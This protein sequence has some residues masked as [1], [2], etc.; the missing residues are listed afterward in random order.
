MKVRH[1]K[2]N[3]FQLNAININ[4]ENFPTD[5]FHKNTARII[6]IGGQ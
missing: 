2:R 3:Y 6:I 5:L 4:T 1:S